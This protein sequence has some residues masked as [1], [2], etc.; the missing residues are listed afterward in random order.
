MRENTDIQRIPLSDLPKEGPVRGCGHHY[1]SS[2]VAVHHPVQALAHFA[3]PLRWEIH[4]RSMLT[5]NDGCFDHL[6][7][8]RIEEI[9]RQ[10]SFL[11]DVR[12]HQRAAQRLP[13]VF[14]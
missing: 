8:R 1:R 6:F 14:G 5:V 2:P 7:N 3:D 9:S 12:L 11:I 13:C 4:L 10:G